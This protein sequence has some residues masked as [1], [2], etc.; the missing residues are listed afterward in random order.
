MRLSENMIKAL[1]LLHNSENNKGQAQLKTALAL[2]TRE[3]VV[4]L[5][6]GFPASTCGGTF[7]NLSVE[8]TNKGKKYCSERFGD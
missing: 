3:L 4:I 8:L 1:S 6:H 5:N 2:E 7:P